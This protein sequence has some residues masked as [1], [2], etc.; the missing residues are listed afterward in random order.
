MPNPSKSS[1]LAGEAY[2]V[3]RE[4][5]LRGELSIGQ[6]ISRRKLA[7]ELGMSFLPMSEALLRLE[8]EGLVESRPRAGTRVRIPT[9]EDVRGNYLVREALE[10]QA[11]RLF[12]ET[13]SREE[14][15]DLLK[16]AGRVDALSQRA[17]G[18]RF[19][20]LRLHEKLHRRIAECGR[21][22]ALCE[23]IDRTCALSSTWLCSSPMPPAD[24]APHRHHQELLEALGQR[25]PEA[26]AEAMRQHI[27]RSMHNTLERLEPYFRM[28][29]KFPE[30]YA[31]SSRKQPALEWLDESDGVS[32]SL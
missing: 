14:A 29:K 16:L 2:V 9:R 23:A 3:V 31:R 11:A 17:G 10:M 5:I 8:H 21:C 1:S 27:Q 15:S 4:R 19:V 6:V 20:Y 12:A 13:A 22:P 24:G 28:S 30:S 25:Q 32:A 26:A 18:N 7:A